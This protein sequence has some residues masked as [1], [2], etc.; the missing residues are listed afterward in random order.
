MAV[1]CTVLYIM[2]DIV[3]KSAHGKVAPHLGGMENKRK[4]SRVVGVS[5]DGSLRV[6]VVSCW[7]RVVKV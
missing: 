2:T 4:A 1:F 5:A 6:G 7:N 3:P